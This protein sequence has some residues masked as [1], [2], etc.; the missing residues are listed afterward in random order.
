MTTIFIL[1]RNIFLY[2]ISPSYESGNTTTI[3]KKYICLDSK[4]TIKMKQSRQKHFSDQI[5]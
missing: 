4:L 1:T 2:I 3:T 5:I